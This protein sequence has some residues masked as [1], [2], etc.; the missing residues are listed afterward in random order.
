[1]EGLS[2]PDGVHVSHG[3]KVG[4]GTLVSTLELEF[5]LKKDIE[6]IDVDAVVSSWKTWPEMEAEIRQICKDKPGHMARCLEETKGKYIDAEGLRRQVETLKSCWGELSGRIRKTILPFSRVYENLKAVGA[7][8]EPEMICVSREHLKE[9]FSFIPF[10]R[11]RFTN[12]DLL[13]RL[14]YLEEFTQTLFGEGGRWEV[15]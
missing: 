9:T 1:M 2:Y 5:L 11:S 12:I 6:N 4:I 10:M 3:F 7:A 13:Y 14:G 15:K 8:Y